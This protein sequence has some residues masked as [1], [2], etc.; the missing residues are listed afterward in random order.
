MD[1][2]TK[3]K[4]VGGVIGLL[5]IVSIVNTQAIIKLSGGGA[6]TVLV[7]SAGQEAQALSSASKCIQVLPASGN[8]TSFVDPADVSPSFDH[9]LVIGLTIKNIC[10]RSISIISDG[11][12]YPNGTNQNFQNSKLEDFP[13]ISNQTLA[14]EY[15]IIGPHVA[16]IPTIYGLDQYDL[17]IPASN[18]MNVE[19]AGGDM[20]VATIGAN[21]QKEFIVYS[22][23]RGNSQNIEHNTRLSLKKIRWFL[24]SSYNDSQLSSNEVKTHSLT[25]AEVSMFTTSYANFNQDG[26]AAG[27][28]IDYDKNGNPIYCAGGNSEG[29]CPEGTIIGFN[30]DGSPIFCQ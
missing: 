5:A 24:T 21:S 19:Y 17:V 27:T 26:C 12:T 14:S 22:Y 16:S 6:D 23:V 29:G 8:H 28:I 9:M 18:I 30:K 10:S 1:L 2:L 4:V 25:P 11:F 7:A 20:K 13:N 15:A 3:N